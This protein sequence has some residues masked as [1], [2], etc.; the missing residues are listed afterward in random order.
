MT[1]LMWLLWYVAWICNTKYFCD[2]LIMLCYYTYDLETRGSGRG[3]CFNWYC[4]T[5]DRISFF[6]WY[7]PTLHSQR[8]RLSSGLCTFTSNIT[9]MA[10]TGRCELL[11]WE[12]KQ[13]RLHWRIELLQ[14]SGQVC[15]LP[16]S[17]RFYLIGLRKS[18]KLLNAIVLN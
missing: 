6:T 3:I 7:T 1:E 12:I 17:L 14:K 11:C 5:H 10:N 2:L 9:L 13:N 8:D 4:K 15:I 18:R 16:P